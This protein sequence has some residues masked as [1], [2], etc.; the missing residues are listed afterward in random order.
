MMT[1][2]HNQPDKTRDAEWRDGEGRRYIRTGDIGR[3]DDDGFLI[4]LDR[5]KDV[6]ISGGFNIY[7]SDIEAELVR[8]DAVVEA[9][10]VGVPSD[11][12]G[13]TPVAFVA[14]RHGAAVDGRGA[15]GLGQCEARQD[16]APLRTDHRR[17]PAAQRDRQG[18]QARIALP[19][20]RIGRRKSPSF[21]GLCGEKVA[22]EVGRM[23]GGAALSG[24]S[25]RRPSPSVGSGRPQGRPSFDGLS[26][27]PLP[28]SGAR[29]ARAPHVRS[30]ADPAITGQRRFGSRTGASQSPGF[31]DARRL[32]GPV[33]RSL[34]STPRAHSGR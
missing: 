14:L 20:P 25:P 5:S 13:E 12:W 15:E 32:R 30:A 17:Q 31:L 18:P 19:S 11:R 16:P 7:P 34:R 9:A 22:D 23:R 29:G 10:V 1:G 8:H 6:I 27:H 33:C 2:Y 28:A 26:R 24:M 21:D 3:F 4:L